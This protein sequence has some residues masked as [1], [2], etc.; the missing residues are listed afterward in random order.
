[1]RRKTLLVGV[2]VIAVVIAAAVGGTYAIF[3]D[4]ESAHVRFQAGTIQIDVSGEVFQELYLNPDGF[5]DWKPGDYEE[6][7][8]HIENT[9]GNEAWIQIYIYET[10][11]WDDPL[12]TPNFWDVAEWGVDATGTWNEWLLAPGTGMD[13]TLWVDF[14]QWVGNDYQ[15][16]QG[17]LLILIVAKQARNK[18]GEGYSC[19]ALE[20]K[21]TGG[22]WLPILG[23]DM[24]GIICY[25]PTASGLHVDLNAY[26][27]TPGTNY[28]LDLTGGDT[29]NSIDPGCQTQDDN[30]AGM[31]PGD[32][33]SSGYW[34]WNTYLEATC[35][36]GNGGEGVY[37]YAGVHTA[38]TADSK[39]SISFGGD[40]A[41][42]SGT[43]AGVG[44]HVKEVTGALPGTAW[45]GVLHE[46]NYLSFVIPSP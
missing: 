43:Y 39:G 3:T 41:L 42:P 2:L 4:T 38:L 18:F 33:Y 34:N 6:F 1:M 28:Q 5:D 13:M 37:N 17:D 9:G 36:A 21:D 8:I 29:N 31:V 30:L 23:N 27:L 44:A 14:P 16:A 32:L 46:M 19:I 11:P 15:G 25:K 20:D 26:G 35:T 45:T 10:G 7:P 24:E 12:T 40:L 22:N